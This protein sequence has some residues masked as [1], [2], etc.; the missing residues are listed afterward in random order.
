MAKIKAKV[1]TILKTRL[2]LTGEVLS[3]NERETALKGTQLEV[4]RLTPNKNDHLKI[5]LKS[6]GSLS[7]KSPQGFIYGPHWEY[8][9]EAVLLP[10][11]YYWQ[12]D[13]PSGEGPR[14]CCGTSNAILANYLLGGE[15]DRQAAD[16]GIAQPESIYLERL[17]FYGD[18]TDHSANTR[19]LADFGIESFWS[20]SLTLDDLYLSLRN[21]IPMV[22]GLDYNDHGHIVCGNGFRISQLGHFLIIHDPNGARLGASNEWLSLLPEAG[23][24]DRYALDTF[25]RL[26]FPKDE[27]GQETLGWGRIV[28]SI[29]GKQTVFAG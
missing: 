16:M 26:W 18:T 10:A 19:A 25:S 12:R 9:D 20:T 29:N 22:M 8:E 6:A 21:N 2:P 14:E 3:R 23:K 24:N 7:F 13:N 11:S 17:S 5:D 4:S 15:L 1:D 28:I 27:N